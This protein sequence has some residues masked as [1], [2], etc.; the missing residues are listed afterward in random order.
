MLVHGNQLFGNGGMGMVPDASAQ[1][2]SLLN[3][4]VQDNSQDGDGNSQLIGATAT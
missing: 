2:E 3:L 1:G 4:R